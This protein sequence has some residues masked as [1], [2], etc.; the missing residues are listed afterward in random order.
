MN[1]HSNNLSSINRRGQLIKWG[2][3]PIVLFVFFFSVYYWLE[4][5]KPEPETRPNRVKKIR[6][7]TYTAQNNRVQ[8]KGHSQGEVL[9]VNTLELKP[10][11]AGPV[12]YVSPNLVN[13][14]KFKKGE[15]LIEIDPSDYELAVIQKNA[16]VAQA[17]QQL[18]QTQAEAKAAAIELQSLGRT[19]ASKLALRE[20]QLKQA[21]ANLKSA[22]AELAMAKLSLARTKIYAPF[23]GRVENESVTQFQYVNKGN[24]LATIFSTELMEVRLPLS[25]EQL[26]Q[27]ALPA[28]YYES[29]ENSP[30]TVKLFG[31]TV[32]GQTSWPAKIVR[33]EAVVDN[34]T[35]SLFAV[36]QI[37]NPYQSATTPLLNGTF[38]YAEIS[39]RWIE[40]GTE[41]P[42]T[43]L[44]NNGE[45]WIVG[46]K[47]ELK[48][49]QANIVQ[50]NPDSIIV[51]GLKNQTRVITSALAM[52]T[53]G[54]KVIPIE[55]KS[56]LEVSK[57][58]VEKQP[59]EQPQEIVEDAS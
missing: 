37:K 56:T 25:I 50:R 7:F 36:A 49:I 22:E 11:V 16:R 55:Q 39:G 8:L 6:V 20:P 17:S 24:N 26:S 44:R 57:Q 4:M 58:N 28:G 48:I 19:S 5:N 18:A 52:A 59:S 53:N 12:T 13:G 10:Q 42:K 1:S 9:P 32:E 35:R 23:D 43:A 30:F 45:L 21:Q 27:I 51:T 31:Q 2:L 3:T 29:Y 14:G 15:L 54:L 41:L 47:N 38:V 33:T 34:K 46:K 40:A